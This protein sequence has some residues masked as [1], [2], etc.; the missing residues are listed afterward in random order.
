MT[1]YYKVNDFGI[2]CQGSV[3]ESC[4]LKPVILALVSWRTPIPKTL[5]AYKNK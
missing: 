1:N 4:L 2:V 5:E 3:S